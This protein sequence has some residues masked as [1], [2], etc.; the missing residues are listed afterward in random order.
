MNLLKYFDLNRRVRFMNSPNSKRN[1]VPQK[2]GR[3][4]WA[5]LDRDEGVYEQS[6]NVLSACWLALTRQEADNLS[7]ADQLLMYCGV[8]MGVY[9]SGV[10]RGQDF[11]PTLLLAAVVSL[12]IIPIV[13]EKLNINP[14]APLIVRF[15]LFVQNGVFWDVLLQALGNIRH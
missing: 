11:R 6:Q 2:P 14:N 13:F 9:F 10:I 7:I 8:L 12:I 15:G 5:N 3:N 1:G 4:H